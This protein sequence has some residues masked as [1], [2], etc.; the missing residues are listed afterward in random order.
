[1]SK[2]SKLKHYTGGCLCGAVRFEAEMD[3]SEPVS[4][5][6]CSICTK[7]GGT[8]AYP[9]PSAFRVT[10]GT[11]HLGEFRKGSS[12]N[13]R[14]FCKHC[15]IHCFSAGFVEELGGE[16]RSVNIQCLDDVDPGELK[17]VYW[18][19]RHDNWEAGTRDRPWPIR[20]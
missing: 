4:R 16:F 9:K 19:G 10:A 12:P 2:D 6:N 18:D 3:L 17:V 11:E 8:Q 15:G 5:C 7:V 13:F 14:S 20:S 1:M